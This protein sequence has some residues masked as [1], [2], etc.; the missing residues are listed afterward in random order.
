MQ[1]VN[2]DILDIPDI[3]TLEP[4]RGKSR[5]VVF[6]NNIDATNYV[7]EKNSYKV[8]SVQKRLTELYHLKCAYCEQKLLDSPKHIE[9][10]RPKSIYYWLAYSWD[11]LFLCCGNCNSAKGNRFKILNNRVDYDNEKFE[12]IHNLGEDYDEEEKPLIINPEKENIIDEVLY[13]KDGIVSSSNNRVQYT[14]EKACNLNRNELVSKRQEIITDFINSFNRHL[15]HFKTK[16]DLSRFEPEIESFI[17]KRDE[18]ESFYTFRYFI[19]NN[20]DVFFKEKSKLKILDI[21]IK[22][23]KK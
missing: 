12:N 23:I 15:E 2:K 3:L 8:A 21:I 19:L 9:H 5:S 14:I 20:L 13:D 6:K 1:K 18:K 4:K 7:D 16:G 17:E 11:N 22:R 10:Y